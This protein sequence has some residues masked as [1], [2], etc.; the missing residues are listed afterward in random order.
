MSKT[1]FL[2]KRI[3]KWLKRH[4][5]NNESTI[6][7]IKLFL[8]TKEKKDQKR[9]IKITAIKLSLKYSLISEGN[10]CITEANL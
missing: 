3:L 7:Y 9:N 4:Y 10:T 8:N 2:T 5:L 6:N 1:I